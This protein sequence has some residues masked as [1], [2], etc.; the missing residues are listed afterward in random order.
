MPSILC[1][2]GEKLGYGE[3]P[4]P[5]EWLAISDTAYDGYAGNI[6]A[7]AL[8]REMK[9]ILECPRCGRLWAFW[10]GFGKPAKVYVV[11]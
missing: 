2:C 6:D 1:T 11:E 9:S 4:N 10:D 3:I 5:I 8:Y 7:E